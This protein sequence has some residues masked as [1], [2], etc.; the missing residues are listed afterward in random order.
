MT[1]KYN[2]LNQEQRYKIE[3]YLEAGKS[4][5]E[6]AAL[7]GVHK[8]TIGRELRRNIPK[9]GR[10]AKI[11]NAG[12]ANDKTKKRHAEKHKHS[13]FTPALK[14]EVKELMEERKYSPE[15]IA[16]H[17]IGK[18]VK[19]VSHECIYKFIWCCKHT[20]QK[21]NKD[22]KNLYKHLKHGKRRR[23]RGNY[24]DTRGLIPNRISIENRPNVVEKRRRFGDFE[25][26]LVMGKNHQ[27]ALLVMLDR[28]SLITFINKLEGKNS[29]VIT[30]KIIERMRELPPLKTMTFDNDQAFSQHEK[31]A[32]ELKLDSYFTRPYTS[33]D[34]GSVENRNGIIRQ[35]FPKKTDFNLID[36]NEI[37]RVEN[38]LNNRPVRKFGYLTPNDVFSQLKVSVALIS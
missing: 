29:T 8:S 6:I 32:R 23:K 37:K 3:A 36:M 35:F 25:V 14:L 17:W 4:R 26:D 18:G 22:Y 5:T 11:Y 12:K 24:K 16:Q 10:G 28:A 30:T 1:K 31:I 15:L 33:Q 2:Q 27:S 38:E 20:N 19:G 9:R 34:K 21:E 13:T 7:L